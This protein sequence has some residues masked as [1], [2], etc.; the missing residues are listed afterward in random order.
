[1]LEVVL[2][3]HREKDDGAKHQLPNRPQLE[4]GG[5]HLTTSENHRRLSTQSDCSVIC[6]QGQKASSTLFFLPIFLPRSTTP[7]HVFFV[8][9]IRRYVTCTTHAS[10]TPI[11]LHH[12]MYSFVSNVLHVNHTYF[13]PHD[14]LSHPCT[15]ML[16]SR[17]QTLYLTATLGKGLGTLVYQTRSAGMR[18]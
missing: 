13:H 18:I 14:N 7:T 3:L 16:V 11:F 6:L 15:C 9:L 17:S 12:A 4:R 10:D 1:M 5:T 2:V 8:Q